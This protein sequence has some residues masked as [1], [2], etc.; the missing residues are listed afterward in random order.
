MSK[1][2]WPSWRYGPKGAAD[3][4]NSEDEVPEGWQD[5]PSK[6]DGN[7]DDPEPEKA[8]EPVEQETDKVER[9]RINALGG[10]VTDTN[11]DAEGWPW[12]PEMHAPTKTKTSKGLWR[13][14]V[15]VSRPEPKP[16]YPLDL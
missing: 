2:E 9:E 11:L 6:V 13:M 16:G 8:E 15:G 3:I 12:E 10:A 7:I 4:F 1:Q 14:K 5:H